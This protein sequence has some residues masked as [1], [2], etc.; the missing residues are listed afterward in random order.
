M[1]TT[2]IGFVLKMIIAL[3]ARTLFTLVVRQ[4][5]GI[6]LASSIVL[7]GLT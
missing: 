5:A 7:L 2:F 4:L 3:F 6:M 1:V